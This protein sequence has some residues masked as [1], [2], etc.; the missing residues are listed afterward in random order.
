MLA[1]RSHPLRR[2][3]P[4]LVLIVSLAPSSAHAF[5]YLEHSYFADRAC[6]EAQ[7]RLAGSLESHPELLPRYLALALACP[8]SWKR[9]YCQGGY[10]LAEGGLNRLAAPPDRSHDLSATLGDFAALAD[11]LPRY[12]PIRNLSRAEQTGLTERALTWLSWKSG[13]AGGVISDVAE[14]ACDSG[15]EVPWA[16]VEE[17]VRSALARAEDEGK[18]PQLPS[19]RL[20]ASQRAPVPRGPYDPAGVYSFDNPQYLDLVRH[21]RN[22]FGAEAFAT[23]LGFHSAAEEIAESSCPEILGLSASELAA[24]ADGL[25]YFQE[26]PWSSMKGGE[27]RQAGCAVLGERVRQ[28]LLEWGKRADP[29]LVAPVRSMLDQLAAPPGDRKLLLLEQTVSALMATVFEGGGLHFLHDSEAG[30][31]LRTFP[32]PHDLQHTRY[33]HD[34]EGKEGVI[35]S[36]ATRT[37]QTEFVAFGDSYL[38]GPE[39]GSSAHCADEPASLATKGDTSACLLQEQRALLV[40]SATASLLDWALGGRVEEEDAPSCPEAAG[41][42]R[43]VCRY[44]PT[45]PPAASGL[46]AW[47]PAPHSIEKGALPVVPEPFSYES[48]L[49]AAATDARGNR[50]G[51]GGRVIFLSELGWRANWMTSYQVGLTSSFASGETSALTLDYCYSFHWRWAA[52]WLINAGPFVYSGLRDMNGLPSVFSGI[53]PAVGTSVLPE[54]WTKV[55]LELAITYRLPITFLDSRVGWSS[56][57]IKIEAHWLELA[58]GLAFQ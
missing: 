26:L 18:V 8:E 5:D 19:G 31:H 12:G 21:N 27:L 48:V 43:F 55:P 45:R 40:A 44:L 22:H 58:V 28:R 37:S 30:G 56:R 6:L 13:D 11:H 24:I 4:I 9:P 23:W 33:Q 42:E 15:I 7:R 34:Q 47:K 16:A 41:P 1:G 25:P 35:A 50:I 36:F 32:S 54:G 49:L 14:S 46:A 2:P 17:D 20:K 29:E 51:V 52:R 10:K 57:A 38:L 53:G 3:L 39:P